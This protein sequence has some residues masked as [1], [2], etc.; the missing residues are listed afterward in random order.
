MENLIKS[1]YKK[2]KAAK[3]YAANRCRRA[4]PDLAD[5]L[6]NCKMFT[7]NESLEELADLMFQ[8]QGREF[9]LANQF[10][11]LHTFRK[12]KIYNPEEL[13]VYIDCGNITLT[14]PGRC[15][16]IGNTRAE[17]FINSTDSHN[18]VVMHGA[19][20]N[21]YCSGYSVTKVEADRKSHVTT[22]AKDHAHVS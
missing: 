8:P 20:A 17:I 11:S 10:P 16:I 6:D 7:G 2:W 19:T 22:S 13:G 12:Y 9:M 15:F 18:V 1:T 21:V 5:Q 3:Q 14:N 4:L